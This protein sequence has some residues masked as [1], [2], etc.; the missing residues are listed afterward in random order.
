MAYMATR[1]NGNNNEMR[2][3]GNQNNYGEARGYSGG[4]QGGYGEMRG[5][6]GNRN[7]Y[8]EMRGGG[9][10]NEM[11][12]GGGNQGNYGEMR[13][14]GGNRSEYNEMRG[15][16]GEPESRY[17]GRDGRWRAGRRR[18]AME[19]EMRMGSD[20]EEKEYEVKIK[21]SNIVEWP[22]GQP[23]D[24]YVPYR[25][26]RQIGFGNMHMQGKEQE[27]EME[28][29]RSSYE[30]IPFDRET[31]EEWVKNMHNEDKSHPKGGKWT[32]EQL[33]PLAQKCGIP[34]EGKKFWEFY[35]MT[36]AMYSDYSEVARKFGITSPEF[37]AFM[38]KAFIDDKDAEDN[39]VSLY[40][41]C[42]AKK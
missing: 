15:D 7:E 39:K 35:A 6:G 28:M 41:E 37:Y 27:R 36:N 2:Q 3:G 33:K 16:Y 29:G 23:E 22:Y 40:Y 30:P 21:P 1:N 9:G 14:G 11:R 31:A 4:N 32:V 19:G 34:S 20:D 24:R 13:R 18:S 42:I 17:R 8:N 5:G 12:Q 10:Y 38:A 25:T 26:N